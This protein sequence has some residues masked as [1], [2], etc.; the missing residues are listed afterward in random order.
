MGYRIIRTTHFYNYSNQTQTYRPSLQIW[1]DKN[2]YNI[3]NI[4]LGCIYS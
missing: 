4:A 1:Y 2:Q 3:T